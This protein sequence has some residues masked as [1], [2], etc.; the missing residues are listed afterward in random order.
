M[1]KWRITLIRSMW[2]PGAFLNFV[3]EWLYKI[4]TRKYLFGSWPTNL[5]LTEKQ[6]ASG[7]YFIS[8]PVSH[9]QSVIHPLLLV[10]EVCPS[11]RLMWL[12]VVLQLVRQFWKVLEN[13]GAESS[14]QLMSQETGPW[15]HFIPF[16]YFLHVSLAGCPDV[17]Y[18]HCLSPG[19][20]EQTVS[21]RNEF[22]SKLLM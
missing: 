4:L 22:L 5:S 8:W 12:T 13:S 2:T 1:G 11:G 16:P 14:G 18:L 3:F 15:G 10:Y 7:Q 19:H 17:K 20:N 21:Q 9:G 6:C